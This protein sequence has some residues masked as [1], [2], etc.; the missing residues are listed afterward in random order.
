MGDVVYGDFVTMLPVPVE[1]V[2]GRA[3][4]ANLKLAIVIGVTPGGGLYFASSEG[5]FAMVLWQLEY[6]KR[7]LFKIH[8]GENEQ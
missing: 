2:L 6:A 4:E 8:G 1:R 5:D 3:Q 7:E